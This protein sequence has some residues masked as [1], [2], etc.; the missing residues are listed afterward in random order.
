MIDL[1]S[2]TL[3]LFQSLSQHYQQQCSTGSDPESSLFESLLHQRPAK[4]SSSTSSS[5]ES[6]PSPSSSSDT[7]ATPPRNSQ[8][9]TSRSAVRHKPSPFTPWQSRSLLSILSYDDQLSSTEK[10][11]VGVVLGLS[12]TQVNRWFCNARARELKRSKKYCALAKLEPGSCVLDPRKDRSSTTPDS[13]DGPASGPPQVHIDPRLF[14]ES[15]GIGSGSA[16]PAAHSTATR[17]SRSQSF[18]VDNEGDYQMGAL[19]PGLSFALDRRLCPQVLRK[20]ALP[21]AHHFPLS[22]PSLVH[23]SL[24]SSATLPSPPSPVKAGDSASSVFEHIDFFP[25]LHPESDPLPSSSPPSC[26]SLEGQPCRLTTPT[27]GPANIS[28]DELLQRCFGSLDSHPSTNEDAERSFLLAGEAGA[29]PQPPTPPVSD[30]Q[31]VMTLEDLLLLHQQSWNAISRALATPPLDASSS[32]VTCSPSPPP[33]PFSYP[34][35]G[36][37]PCP[38]LSF[39]PYSI[40]LPDSASSSSDSDSG[41]SMPWSPPVPACSTLHE[42]GDPMGS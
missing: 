9:P 36:S 4:R 42:Y 6:S 15:A 27:L 8:K 1:Q 33:D 29:R 30:P 16:L 7:G 18:L 22:C 5:D 23:P 39:D 14:D 11:L 20:D 26:R 3:P 21:T 41:L 10:E 35:S 32:S 17:S 24:P 31:Q 34:T 38:N 40:I 37:V 2:A 25:P 13:V 19:A 28:F 12:A